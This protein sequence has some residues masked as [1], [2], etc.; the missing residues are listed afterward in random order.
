MVESMLAARKE[1][2]SPDELSN[3]GLASVT[4]SVLAAEILATHDSDKDG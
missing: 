1:V 4:A 2:K 3:D